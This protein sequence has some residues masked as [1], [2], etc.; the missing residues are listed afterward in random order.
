[1]RRVDANME[2]R[3]RHPMLRRLSKPHYVFRPS[4]VVCRLRRSGAKTAPLPWGFEIE[5]QRDL[6]GRAI[7]RMGVY[8]LVVSETIHRLLDSGETAIDGG[9]SIGYTTSLMAARVRPRGRVLAFEPNPR[10]FA[11]LEANAARWREQSLE[12]IVLHP[13]GLSDRGRDAALSA[14][15]DEALRSIGATLRDLANPAATYRVR[16]VRLDSCVDAPV[17]LLKLDVEGHELEALR[18]AGS[19][20]SDNLIRDIVFEEHGT[21]PTPVTELLE[22]AGYVCFKLEERFSGPRLIEDLATPS[23][24]GWDPP[25]YLA[26]ADPARAKGRLAPRGWRCLRRR[27]ARS[28]SD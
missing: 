16:L 26:T 28:A 20:V 11:I 7:A 22:A 3:K 8:D 13:E 24:F 1:M 18:G 25:N 9:A 4:Q 12:A 6:Q 5:L 21:P 23:K 14:P 10:A 17:G 19:L 27:A 2:D 15:Q